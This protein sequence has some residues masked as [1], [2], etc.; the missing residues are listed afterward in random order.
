MMTFAQ[1]PHCGE[2]NFTFTR[3]VN[4]DRCVNCGKSLASRDPHLAG[5][6]V[7]CQSSSRPDPKLLPGAVVTEV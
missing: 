7:S 4:L 5:G 2:L 3:W 6:R 1:C